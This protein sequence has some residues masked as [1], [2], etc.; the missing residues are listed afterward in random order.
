MFTKPIQPESEVVQ[1]EPEIVEQEVH[2]AQNTSETDLSANNNPPVANARTICVQC[3]HSNPSGSRFCNECGSQ[4]SSLC[5]V[6]F[7]VSG[8]EKAWYTTDEYVPYEYANSKRYE[9][10][11]TFFQRIFTLISSLRPENFRPKRENSDLQGGLGQFHLS[12]YSRRTH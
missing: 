8:V 2:L 6:E 1:P 9:V 4:L 7:L 3:R 11:D 12:P 10:E 5:S